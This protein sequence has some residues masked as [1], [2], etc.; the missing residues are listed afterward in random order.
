MSAFDRVIGYESVKRE[1]KMYA[2]VLRNYEKYKKLGVTPPNGIL[3]WGDPGLGK[4]LMANCFITETGYK[5]F[6]IRKEK[7]DG[8]FVNTIKETYEKA[9]KESPSI[10]FLDDMDKFSNTDDD[11]KNTDE[12]VTVQT[13]IDNCKD[14]D[15]FTI[16]TINCMYFLPDSLLRAGR[17][18]EIIEIVEPE[19]NDAE[20]IIEYYLNRMN[21]KGDIDLKELC[22]ILEG[23][24]SAELETIINKAGIYAGSDGRDCVCQKDIIDACL[25]MMFDAPLDD[26]CE[27]RR[28]LARIA[29]HEA[30]HAVISEILN[31]GS[32]NLLTIRG[33]ANSKEGLTKI[34]KS[35]DESSKRFKENTVIRLLGG[36]AAS[37]V[38]F[39]ES[40]MGCNSDLS[41]AFD[42]VEK[43]VDNYCSLGFETFETVNSSQYL[44]E[45]K[46]RQIAS[47]VD[48]Y[49][50]IAKEII[51]E[52]RDFLEVIETELID[53]KILTMRDID[54]IKE[55]VAMNRKK[56]EKSNEEYEYRWRNL[57]IPSF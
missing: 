50:R 13:C 17:F 29:V 43:F 40:D 49:Y 45:K 10:V 41:K 32:V 48:R 55:S 56:S 34:R 31:P 21:L 36:K 15:V 19:G 51:T 38:I 1:L 26:G 6:I 53:K 2:D 16:A 7:T 42:I 23:K 18:D 9:K 46:D 27:N 47:E 37:E 33:Y 11:H 12:Y 24:S 22:L 57:L 4:T 54:R 3:L 5:S 28:K 30:G 44:L 14:K 52:N 20:E 39:G 25:R 35:S 8:D